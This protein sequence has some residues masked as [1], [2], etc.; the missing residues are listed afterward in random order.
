MRWF[1]LLAVLLAAVFPGHAAPVRD[2][3]V[4]A[5][6]VSDVAVVQPGSRFRVALRL[7]MDPHWHTYWRNP[8][9]SGL[10]T[11]IEWKLPP[12]LKAGE[13]EWPAPSRLDTAGLISYGYAGEIFLLV[14]FE[15]A[16][17]LKPGQ[18]LSLAG[19]TTWLACEQSCIPGKADLTLDLTVGAASSPSP[20]EARIREA[21]AALPRPD[22]GV[23]AYRDGADVVLEVPGVGEAEFFPYQADVIGYAPQALQDGKLRLKPADKMPDRLAGVL[24]KDGRAV[25]VDAAVQAAPAMPPVPAAG[26][27]GGLG[28]ALLFAFVGGVILNLMP[29]VFPVLA[30]KI[31]GFVEAAGEE[32]TRPWVH[33]AVFSLGVLLSF[34]TLAG[35]LLLLKAAGKKLGW[36]FQM[37]EPAFVVAMGVLFFFIGLNLLG[38]FE[39]GLGLT[40]LG[41]VAER[42]TGLSNSFWSGVLATLVATPCTAPFMGG[43][44][45]YALAAPPLQSMLIFTSLG[46][47][48]AAPYMI[49]S[50][51]PALLRF[52][53]RPG[54]WMESFKQFLAFPMLAT[55]AG[56]TWVLAQQC[57]HDAVTLFLFG[58]VALG[59][60]AW[61]YGRWGNSLAQRTKRLGL[62][63]ASLMLV[64]GCTMTF[65]SAT[66]VAE[67]KTPSDKPREGIVWEAW[68]PE[69]VEAARAEGKPV[70]V[71]FTA[72]W[73]LICQSN[74]RFVLSRPDVTKAFQD[75]GVLMLKADWTNKDETIAAGLAEFGRVGVPLYVFYPPGGEPVVRDG[76]LNP[77]ELIGEVQRLGAR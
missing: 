39:V 30:V 77:S 66:L 23:K 54:A 52:V 71:D 60:A 63:F 68:S 67:S 22:P 72:A 16:P 53:P 73:C 58:L 19:H 61:A 41:D 64:A 76:T 50:S 29:C 45:G 17:D 70:F 18:K 46:L 10:A 20:W 35:A 34:W 74:E 24:V 7:R 32:K 75:G 49:L 25:A 55:T 44:L 1:V 8:G 36:G 12:G 15:A 40:R 9:E 43:A 51:T 11:G 59:M 33:G 14:P 27:V 5:E 57:G 69:R 26:Q 2:G 37:Q 4:E 65:G 28:L 48:M 47:G 6:L 13:L 42:K 31:I 56:L 38:V 21:E 62:G 3:N